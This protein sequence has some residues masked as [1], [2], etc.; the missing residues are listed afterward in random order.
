MN[1]FME[2][3]YT[4]VFRGCDLKASPIP[5]HCTKEQSMSGSQL[6]TEWSMD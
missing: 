5:M 1:L 6:M 2:S 3:F 4:L